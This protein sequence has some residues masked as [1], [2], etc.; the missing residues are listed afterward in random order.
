VTVKR[1]G[2]R[3]V[4]SAIIL[5]AEDKG[6]AVNGEKIRAVWDGLWLD[7]TYGPAECSIGFQPVRVD[8]SMSHALVYRRPLSTRRTEAL[9]V[10][11]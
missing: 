6:S 4:Q 11:D 10:K 8:R 9:R 2:D 3:I 5:K 7:G 1:S